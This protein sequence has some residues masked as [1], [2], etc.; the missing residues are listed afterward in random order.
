MDI[1]SKSLEPVLAKLE[2]QGSLG[3]SNWFEVV[4]HDGENWCAY[5]G[6]NTFTDG[7]KV[8]EWFYCEDIIG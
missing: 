5:A 7:E 4:Y 3:K 1:P 2:H 8:L 6:S